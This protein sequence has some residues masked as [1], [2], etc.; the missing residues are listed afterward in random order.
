M[1][2]EALTEIKI[3]KQ[4]ERQ[5]LILVEDSNGKKYLK[6][7]INEDKREIY[8]PLSKINNPSIPKIFY[9]DFNGKTL[10]IEE[11]IEGKTLSAILEQNKLTH[12]QIRSIA[13]QLLNALY[14]LHSSNIIHRD[15]KPDNIM[16]TDTNRVVLIDYDIARIYRKELRKDTE[17]LGT[18]GYAPIEQFGMMPT[19]FKTDIYAFG[20]TLKIMLEYSKIRWY[21]YKIADKCSKI[22]PSLRYKNVK[23]IKKAITFNTIKRFFIC[24]LTVITLTGTL[25]YSSTPHFEGSFYGFEPTEKEI[26]YANYSFFSSACIFSTQQPYEHILF[27]DDTSKTGKIKL[28]K[29]NTVI[30]A[31]ITLN[32]GNLSVSLDDKKGHTYNNQFSFNNQYEYKKIYT[33]NLRKN[34]D[35]ICY[36]FDGEEGSELLLGLNEGMFKAE[37]ERIYNPFNYCIA[38]CIIYDKE[39][40]FTLCKGDMFS[41]DY[42]FTIYNHAR[43]LNVAW[44]DLDDVAGY[45]LKDKEIK[46]TF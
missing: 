24:I 5:K 17:I 22:D 36:D 9:V 16:L 45:I 28:G 2:P 20:V 8:K 31:T 35:I 6:R 4:N 33:E 30:D 26:E 34:A 43:R 23:E 38:W 44:E 10:V 18:F 42:A 25:I 21:L 40:G 41:K 19:D 3:L 39:T 46:P 1:K 13:K 29:N 27:I 15:I 12:K 37:E 7:E 14:E 11:F 32:N